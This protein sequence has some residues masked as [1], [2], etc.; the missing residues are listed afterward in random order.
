MNLLLSDVRCKA[1]SVFMLMISLPVMSVYGQ[2][3]VKREI[4]KKELTIGQPAPPITVRSWLKSDAGTALEKGM[5]YVIDFNSTYCPPCVN[6]IPQLHKIANKFKGKVKVISIYNHEY[7]TPFEDHYKNVK[8]RVEM[9]GDDLNF[10]V[11][12]DVPER[13]TEA[14]WN[15]KRTTYAIVDVNGKIAFTGSSY[16]GQWIDDALTA[17]LNGESLEPLLA[18]SKSGTSVMGKDFKIPPTHPKVAREFKFQIEKDSNLRKYQTSIDSIME[19]SAVGESSLPVHILTFLKDRKDAAA[20]NA[21]LKVLPVIAD[22]LEYWHWEGIMF[23]LRL[24]N[25]LTH[26]SEL[27]QQFDWN[28]ASAICDRALNDFHLKVFRSD[29][30]TTKLY[31]LLS[32]RRYDEAMVMLEKSKGPSKG[33]QYASSLRNREYHQ[34][35]AKYLTLL[36]KSGQADAQKWLTAAITEQ[37]VDLRK[38]KDLVMQHLG[39]TKAALHITDALQA[40]A[41]I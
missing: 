37:K 38:M 23:N 30:V 35:I 22:K 24:F 20:I 6:T 33:K 2:T 3:P 40:K 34:L 18:A 27:L 36:N 16:N 32:A 39:K 12:I 10:S 19:R 15:G 4:V 7:L 26:S 31:A 28:A 14:A 9:F 25:M 11:G 29:Y 13:T 1:L 8:K 41:N 21:Y 5:L 17:L